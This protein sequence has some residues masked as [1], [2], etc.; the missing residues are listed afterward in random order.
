M[1]KIKN[2]MSIMNTIEYGFKDENDNNI[3]NYNPKK[4]DEEFYDFYYLLTPEELLLK[5]CGVCWDQVELERYLFDKENINNRTYFICTYDGENLPS[6]TFL[7]F[8]HNNKYFWFEHSWN[9]YKGIHEYNSLKELL[10]DVKEKFI[11]NNSSD[12][13]NE[14]TFVYEYEKPKKHIGCQEF[15]NFIE[16]Q[17]LIKLNT[18]LYFYH[19]IN[20][21][22]D[23]SN[24][25]ISLQYMYNN[26]MYDL[27]DKNVVKYKNRIINDWNIKKY[28]GKDTLTREEYIDGLNIFR[29]K[30][31]SSY[32]YFFKY[33][34]YKELGNKMKEILKYKDIYRININ[35]EEVMK[36]IKDIFYGYDMSNSEN[37]LLNKEYY[38]KVT[39][40]EY[41]SKYDDSL[42][43][44]F[45]R[46]NHIGISF[47][48]DKCPIEYFEKVD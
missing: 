43:M 14:Y 13:N 30:Y 10:L 41:F 23:L 38:E 22:S 26:K 39:Q 1:E 42:E 20:K 2:I 37:K 33:P 4:W 17:K 18:P 9:D 44:N 46:L 36:N 19:L 25:L 6:H 34:P 24:G 28:Q 27:F 47:I 21:D 35:D 32:I 40:K 15:Y 7:T 3:I 45:S 11:N 31:G 5:K 8:Q 16:T 29:G 12:I 48:N